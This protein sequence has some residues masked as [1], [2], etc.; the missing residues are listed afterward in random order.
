M[1]HTKKHRRRHSLKKNKR[2]SFFKHTLNKGVTNI[3]RLVKT[4]SKKYM[5]K[6][7]TGLEN[8]GSNVINS[9]KKTVPFLQ[10]ITR[11]AFSVFG[12]KPKRN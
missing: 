7:K 6:V 2:S 10:K 1:G 9:S 3:K 11:K 8:V 5:P 4:S 12:L